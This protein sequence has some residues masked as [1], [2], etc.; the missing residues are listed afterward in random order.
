ME[1]KQAR[2]RSAQKE[3]L[4][5]E[6]KAETAVTKETLSLSGHPI[7]PSKKVQQEAVNGSPPEGTTYATGTLKDLLTSK[8]VLPL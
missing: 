7:V 5:D 6:A 3:S 4:E 2:W 8:T 1:A